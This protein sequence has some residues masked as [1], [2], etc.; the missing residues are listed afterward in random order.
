M[1]WRSI[2]FDWN[3]ARAFLVTAE[4][5]SL[6]AA[7]RAL[8]MTQSTLSRQV[9]G[10]ER[11][12]G[13]A[14]FERVGRGFELTP[15]GSGLIDYVRAMG[16][17]A[18]Q[19][20]LSA[21]GKSDSL[22]GSVCISALEA[23]AVFVLPSI[24][25]RLRK[26]EPGI[27]IEIVA[28]NKASDL[29]RREADIA[30]RAFQPTEP[31]L[32]ARKIRSFTYN[33]Y[34][35]NTYLKKLNNPQHCTDLGSADFIGFDNTHQFMDM[36]NE[37]GLNLTQHNFP[38]SVEN[39]AAHWALVKQGMGIGAMLEDVGEADPDVSRVLADFNFPALDV[40]LVVHR[41]LKTN[42][43]VRRVFDFLVKEL[44]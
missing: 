31:D 34:A 20:S 27:S 36:L 10:L 6:S 29:K 24:V 30:I 23:T 12:L 25:E 26:A 43:R 19:L 22:E 44:S 3:R 1:D 7:A 11:E 9:S 14:L 40:W 8:G 5:G 18:S 35:S 16:E 15:S 21:T 32:I 28:S 4:E 2:T 38:V 37:H 39:H 33:L 13:V 42:K 17:A 41:E